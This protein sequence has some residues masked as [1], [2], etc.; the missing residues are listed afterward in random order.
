MLGPVGQTYCV[1]RILTHLT[2]F[3]PKITYKMDMSITTHTHTLAR[4]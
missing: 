3:H 1:L 4:K 2:S